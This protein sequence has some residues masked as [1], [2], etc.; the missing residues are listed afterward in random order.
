MLWF[1]GS[2]RVGHDWE[3]ELNWAELDSTNKNKY[4]LWQMDKEDVVY[5]YNEILFHHKKN[6]ILTFAATWM[7]LGEY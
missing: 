6:E 4:Q 2:Q 5:L 1:M 3:T 7:E